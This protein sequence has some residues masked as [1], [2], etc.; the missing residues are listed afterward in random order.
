MLAALQFQLFKFIQTK[1]IYARESFV[2]FELIISIY[3]STVSIDLHIYRFLSFY[4]YN[5]KHISNC[6][7]QPKILTFATTFHV[8]VHPT[9]RLTDQLF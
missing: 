1:H 2:I 9:D 8:L 3:L 5:L 6:S 4:S 7:N